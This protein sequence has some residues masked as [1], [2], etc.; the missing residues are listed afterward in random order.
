MCC[1]SLY[2]VNQAMSQLCPVF[3]IPTEPEICVDTFIVKTSSRM[4]KVTCKIDCLKNITQMVFL[5][6]CLMLMHFIIK[7]VF[8]QNFTYLVLTFF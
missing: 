6:A 5:F 3:D 8:K 7:A 1:L 4:R 2:T